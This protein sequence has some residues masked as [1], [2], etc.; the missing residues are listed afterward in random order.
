MKI[1]F[2]WSDIDSLR[3]V[4]D[5]YGD[6]PDMLFGENS[7]G[8]DQ[9]ISIGHENIIV[10]TFQTNGWVRRNVFWYDG[11]IEESYLEKW[12]VE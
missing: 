5:E 12:N 11:T 3:E 4:M 1:E 7:E 9:Q 6:F 2:N 10:D 8:E